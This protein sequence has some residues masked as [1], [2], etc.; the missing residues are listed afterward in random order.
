LAY[1]RRWEESEAAFAKALELDPNH[2][3]TWAAMSD[4]SVLDGRVADGLAQIEKAL[5]LN[6]YPAC[7]YLCH[8]GQAQYAARDYEAA[9]AT[10]R[11]E[12]TY[13]T[14]SR[15]FLAATL[16]QLGHHE[17]AL[18]EA[19]LFLI[20]H[21]HFTIGHWLSSQPLRDASVR[22]HFVDGFRK[23]GLPEM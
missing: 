5:R 21:P 13:R 9:A 20:A 23:A 18:R 4:V 17:E 3:D 6:P 14:N 12:D 2:A 10:L 15:K 8:L 16:A 7:W 11:R 1:E 19:E 22:D